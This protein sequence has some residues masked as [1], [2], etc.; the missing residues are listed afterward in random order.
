MFCVN[1][2]LLLIVV[3]LVV[4]L[5]PCMDGVVLSHDNLW[6]SGEKRLQCCYEYTRY[7]CSNDS[8]SNTGIEISWSEAIRNMNYCN[9]LTVLR[10]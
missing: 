6:L 8:K 4:L 2:S 10:G 9:R 5:F 1:V 3:L 7:K